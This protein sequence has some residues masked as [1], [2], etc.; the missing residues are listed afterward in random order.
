MRTRILLSLNSTVKEF[1][2]R[3]FALLV[4]LVLAVVGPASAQDRGW[5]D[6]NYLGATM[7][8]PEL[9]DAILVPQ[10]FELATYAVDY[11]F[12]GGKG[13]SIGGGGYFTP[14]I[15]IGVN[16]EAVKHSDPALLAIRIP[17][18]LRFNAFGTDAAE[19]DN[20]LERSETAVHI[21]LAL[22]AVNTERAQVRIFGGPSYINAKQDVVNDIRYVQN[23]GI[24][25]ALNDVNITTYV[26]DE[27]T[28]STWGFNVGA[29]VGVFFTPNV[30]VGGG[31]LISRGT[32][33]EAFVEDGIKVGGVRFGGGLRLK[34]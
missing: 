17:H 20:D 14:L 31:I 30:G 27:E 21:Q 26:S 3:R 10:N 15:G 2:M 29:D 6:V 16:I 9:S 8:E 7:A 34:F 25:T 24:F 28:E 33:G 11:D 4:G 1:R 23:Y 19:T 18:P 12:S 5:L 32:V 13:F 22:R